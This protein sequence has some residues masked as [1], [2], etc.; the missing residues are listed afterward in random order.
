MAERSPALKTCIAA[1]WAA[2]RPT[3][4]SPPSAVAATTARRR[5]DV[6]GISRIGR[7]ADASAPR[8]V[9]TNRVG[10]GSRSTASN[11]PTTATAIKV[12]TIVR[13]VSAGAWRVPRRIRAHAPSPI[14]TP[15][16]VTSARATS[17]RSDPI[18]IQS[19]LG[20]GLVGMMSLASHDGSSGDITSG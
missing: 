10:A 3:K 4:S 9:H 6:S 14:M 11:A 19:L 15:T 20:H 2:A 18:A 5:A 8:I 17:P 16:S 7:A 12:A 1:V 13:S